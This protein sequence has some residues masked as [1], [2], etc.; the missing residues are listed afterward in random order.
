[1]ILKGVGML[2]FPSHRVYGSTIAARLLA[3]SLRL[4]RLLWLDCC[5]SIVTASLTCCTQASY[6]RL[7]QKNPLGWSST[8][9]SHSSAKR[10]HFPLRPHCRSY[11]TRIG[12]MGYSRTAFPSSRFVVLCN[13]YPCVKNVCSFSLAFL[14]KSAE[15]VRHI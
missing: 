5:G 12:D 2:V 15:M 11:L 13:T 6:S 1:M 7:N 14:P 9:G 3:R 10:R 8:Q 4:D